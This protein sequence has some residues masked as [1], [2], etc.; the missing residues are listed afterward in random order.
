MKPDTPIRTILFALASVLS[1]CAQIP[2]V[3]CKSE[4][5]R[6]GISEIVAYRDACDRAFPEL[7]DRTRSAMLPLEKKYAGCQAEVSRPGPSREIIAMASAMMESE[8]RNKR[9]KCAE[10]PEVVD[11]ALNA[12]SK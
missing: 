8:I 3:P 5:E 11:R 10:L 4:V 12:L 1:A 7:R 6:R 9:D 2:T